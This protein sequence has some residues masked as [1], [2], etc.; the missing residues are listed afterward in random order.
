MREI[1]GVHR[2][3]VS[4]EMLATVEWAL[5]SGDVQT[6]QLAYAVLLHVMADQVA[7][8]QEESGQRLLNSIRESVKGFNQYIR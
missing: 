2:G 1:W 7:Q 5:R 4:Q 6:Q 3:D 8:A